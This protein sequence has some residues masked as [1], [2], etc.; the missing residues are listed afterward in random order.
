MKIR[1]LLIYII[2]LLIIGITGCC[3]IINGGLSKDIPT[4]TI[5]IN[6][7]I[8]KLGNSWDDVSSHEDQ[9]ITKDESFDYCVIDNNGKVLI[10]T[11]DD[12]A[13]SI[14]SATSNYDIIRDIEVDGNVTGKIIIHNP[15]TEIEKETNI[16]IAAF[17]GGLTFLTIIVLVTY[18]LYLRSRI[19]APFAKLKNFATRIAG[20]NLDT[21]LEMDKDNVFGAFTESFDIMREELKASREREAEALKSRKELVAQLSHDIKTPVASIK[22]MTDVMSLIAQDEDSKETLSA[23]NGKADQIDNL[24]SNLF[25]ATLE[26]LEQ[27]EVRPE[28]TDSTEI[29]KIVK[30]AD[31]LNKVS[32]LDIRE[33]V[34]FFDKMRLEQVI[35]N[36]IFNSYKYANTEIRVTSRF[37]NGNTDHLV[38]TIA[39]KGPGVPE[40]ELELITQKFKRGSNAGSK[41][42]SG[43]GLYISDYLMKRMGGDLV[44]K[45]LKDGFAV[46]LWI[47]VS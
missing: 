23:I 27:L 17:I 22:A 39:D 15:K 33:A 44:V 34:V 14:S 16:K 26:E 25:H 36:V 24:I 29:I 20:G 30:E 40:S 5:D 8:V 2:S 6:R 9:L 3:I 47:K 31:Y 37:E 43:L 1:Y 42:G 46:E 41:D 32:E 7:C 18:Y 13:M 21:P 19:I 4:H 12:M 28:D 45:N 35:S 11:R 10:F 38:I